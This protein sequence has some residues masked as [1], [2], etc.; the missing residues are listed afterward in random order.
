MYII[1]KYIS[2]YMYVIYIYMYMSTCIYYI[3]VNLYFNISLIYILY[4]YYSMIL[5]ECINTVLTLFRTHS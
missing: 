3:Y 5:W 4:I 1:D 2:V